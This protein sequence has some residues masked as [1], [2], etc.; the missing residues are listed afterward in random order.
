VFVD[1]VRESA[2]RRLPPVLRDSLTI[3]PAAL[4]PRAALV[5]VASL[6][7]DARSR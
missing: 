4:G 1:D 2:R 6:A 5:G 7:R 3:A